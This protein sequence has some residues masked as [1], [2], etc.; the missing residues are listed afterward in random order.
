MTLKSLV[1]LY[2]AFKEI[3]QL[4][5]LT[6][7]FNI[8]FKIFVIKY[9]MKVRVGVINVNVKITFVRLDLSYY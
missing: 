7:G 5:C 1:I 9:W 4:I 8:V 2:G 6:S 3:I